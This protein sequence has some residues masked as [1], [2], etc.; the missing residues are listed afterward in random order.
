MQTYRFC[1]E[2]APE[3]GWGFD[4]ETGDPAPVYI[5]MK[6]DGSVTEEKYHEFH[7]NQFKNSIA[8]QYGIPVEHLKPITP[9]EYDKF[10]E[11]D[12]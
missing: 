3:S 5:Q 2:I 12:E 6:L 7:E 4:T 11:D 9:E 1:Y 10:V 8:E